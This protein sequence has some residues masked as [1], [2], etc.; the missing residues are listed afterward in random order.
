MYTLKSLTYPSYYYKR[1][2]AANFN[3]SQAYSFS[4]RIQVW[5][6]LNEHM[7]NKDKTKKRK[8]NSIVY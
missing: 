2:R 5:S 4:Y 8:L 7:Y 6:S 3:M 1:K